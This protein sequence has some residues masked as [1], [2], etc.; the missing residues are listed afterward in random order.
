M[1]LHAGQV[2]LGSSL[3]TSSL[4]PNRIL[5]SC[6][7]QGKTGI[8]QRVRGCRS[9]EVHPLTGGTHL[10]PAQPLAGT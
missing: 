9:L 5:D 3:C 7:V 6:L 10:T 4:L 8:T 1:Q 2:A